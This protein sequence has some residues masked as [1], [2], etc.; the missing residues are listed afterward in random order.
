MK[1]A[2]RAVTRTQILE[3][4]CPVCGAK[5]GEPCSRTGR[6]YRTRNGG[7]WVTRTRALRDGE[8]PP[9]HQQRMWL[10]QGHTLRRDGDGVWRIDEE[11]SA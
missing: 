2:T 10:R 1:D 7:R 3:V 6:S 5:P 11:A 9:S 4:G 8:I